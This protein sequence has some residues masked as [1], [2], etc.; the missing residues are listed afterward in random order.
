M[1]GNLQ[2]SSFASDLLLTQLEQRHSDLWP[3]R[4]MYPTSTSLSSRRQLESTTKRGNDLKVIVG[5]H[6]T[7]PV[8]R[9]SP[10]S[11]FS[12]SVPSVI[13][14]NNDTAITYR[15]HDDEVTYSSGAFTRWNQAGLRDSR[16]APVSSTSPPSCRPTFTLWPHPSIFIIAWTCLLRIAFTL[17][18]TPVTILSTRTALR[19]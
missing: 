2:G 6:R 10:F 8:D 14:Q 18:W 12:A 15:Q 5:P 3:A 1:I 9:V 17:L 19:S 4:I 11:I 7:W 16:L 13:H